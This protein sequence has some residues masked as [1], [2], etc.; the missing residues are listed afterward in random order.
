ME[1]EEGSATLLPTIGTTTLHEIANSQARFATLGE[2]SHLT[3]LVLL[4]YVGVVYLFNPLHF[5]KL[6]CNI[7]T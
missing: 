1:T 2:T 7:P 4:L 6:F 3:P 5:F